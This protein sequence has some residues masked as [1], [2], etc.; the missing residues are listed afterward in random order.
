MLIRQNIIKDNI[1]K[2]RKIIYIVL[3]LIS[4]FEAIMILIAFL[5]KDV[6]KEN[7]SIYLTCYIV[8]FVFSVG[9]LLINYFSAKHPKINWLL[10][11]YSYFYVV[12]ICAW[13]LV[14]S[15]LD[16]KV[17]N[18]PIVY[19]TIFMFI[20]FFLLIDPIA[21]SFVNFIGFAC[22]LYFEQ[23]I[24]NDLFSGFI[25]NMFVFLV[26]VLVITWKTYLLL[27]NKYDY[28]MKLIHLTRTDALTDL[29]NRRMLDIMIDKL[30]A[31]KKT[32]TIVLID[33]DN[34]KKLNDSYGHSVG[35]NYLVI[36]GSLLKD[37]FGQENVYRYGGDEFTCISCELS[38]EEIISKLIAI[39]DYLKQKAQDKNLQISG[40]IY[41]TNVEDSV[42]EI[43]TK[44]DE[45]L[46]DAKDT[47]KGSFVVYK[48]RKTN[49][50]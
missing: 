47:R 15:Y 4:F 30:L 2:N 26:M 34:F 29:N 41:N 36:I 32:F 17:G 38:N 28:Q 43:F 16:I 50:K 12:L 39:N 3:S 6:F 14:I 21:Y 24:K 31:E 22:M 48:K 5:N 11:L 13:A 46:Y 42:V 9:G 1:Q 33:I 49:N 18:Y 40:G 19:F 45:G 8:L 37:S 27:C 20:P 23:T 10:Y 25:V 35:D 7:F 44:A